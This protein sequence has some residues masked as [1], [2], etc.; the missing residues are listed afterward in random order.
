MRP[1]GTEPKIKYYIQNWSSVDGGLDKVR[2][3]VDKAA[4]DLEKA[5]LAETER[6]I[7]N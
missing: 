7:K 4:L 2:G 3:A 5:I 6:Y 1:S